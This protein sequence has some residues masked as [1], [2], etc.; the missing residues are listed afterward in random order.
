MGITDY[1]KKAA[2]RMKAR[3]VSTPEPMEM[4]YDP[5]QLSK[6]F[7]EDEFRC[8]CCGELHPS[9]VPAALVNELEAVRKYFGKPVKI[10][11]GY[12]CPTHNKNV[13]GA[14]R[15]Q[16]LLGIAADHYIPGVP[17]HKVHAFHASRGIVGGLGK[18]NSFTHIDVRPGH[19]R[20]DRT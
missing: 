5:G 9:G 17:A 2:E 6:H 20:W 8:R 14:K 16:H 10:N 15:S 1:M 11:S 12:R 7:H 18:Y 4:D 13:G 3:T 19:A